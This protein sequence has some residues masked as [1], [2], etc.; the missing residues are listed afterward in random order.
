MHFGLN[1]PQFF[2]EPNPPGFLNTFFSLLGITNIL[3][4]CGTCCAS[5]TGNISHLK[6]TCKPQAWS[7]AVSPS[8]AESSRWNPH[9]VHLFQKEAGDTISDA[10][11]QVLHSVLLLVILYTCT[12]CGK[13]RWKILNGNSRRLQSINDARCNAD[14][15]CCSVCFPRF[16]SAEWWNCNLFL[17][18]HLQS[19]LICRCVL[20]RRT[21]SSAM[22]QRIRNFRVS[23]V[24]LLHNSK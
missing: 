3:V 22:G 9:R 23:V 5:C 7:I 16:H 2:K 24:S 13:S 6:W 4:A 20:Q 17:S 15:S 12:V 14:K 1:K 10:E 18:V 19:G 21:F 11:E 8:R